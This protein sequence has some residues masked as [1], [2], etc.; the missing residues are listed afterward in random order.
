[1][2]KKI[3]NYKFT[4]KDLKFFL[5][6]FPI[7]GLT[8]AYNLF[9]ALMFQKEFRW[10]DVIFLIVMILAFMDTKKKL[11]NNDYRTA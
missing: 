10:M 5:W 9:S 2:L 1:M 7:I 11:K 6:F 8:Y 4:L 3:K